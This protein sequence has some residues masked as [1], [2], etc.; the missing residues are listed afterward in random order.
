MKSSK[1]S[2]PECKSP[3]LTNADM[4]RTKLP[5]LQK[6]LKKTKRPQ[7]KST[8]RGES[9]LN[10]NEKFSEDMHEL[11]TIISKRYKP[12]PD[13]IK[14]TK[15]SL[16]YNPTDNKN[17]SQKPDPSTSSSDSEDLLQPATKSLFKFSKRVYFNRRLEMGNR[18]LLVINFEGV[19]GE[20]FKENFWDDKD[21]SFHIRKGI[22]PGLR[23]LSKQFQ[24]ALFFICSKSDSGRVVSYLLSKHVRIDAAYTSE[25]LNRWKLASDKVKRPLKYSEH[26]QNYSQ[27]TIDFGIQ[28]EVIS[29]ML[30]LTSYFLEPGGCAVGSELVVQNLHS[31]P[32]YLW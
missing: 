2:H 23:S 24:I 17:P 18:N 26:I 27:L 21:E 20:F 16:S 32:V 9:Q 3:D 10:K 31:I 1:P 11:Q 6:A 13:P 8:S 5:R 19:L 25:N 28:H 7:T 30:V 29:R 15:T 12:K 14:K 4:V 22:I